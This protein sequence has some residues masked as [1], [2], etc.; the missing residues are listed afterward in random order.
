MNDYTNG[1]I[2]TAKK[3]GI[4]EKEATNLLKAAAQADPAIAEQMQAGSG[5]PGAEQM[6]QGQ[7]PLPGGE[8]DSG[9]PP[10]LEQLINSLPPEVLEQLLAE[11]EQELQGGGDPAAQGAPP[12]GM[13]P[14][15]MQG[16]M[17][18]EG[19]PKQG[20]ARDTILAKTAEYQE[21]FVEAANYYGVDRNTTVNLYKQAMVEMENNPV[22]A[23]LFV[24]SKE[25]RAAHFEGFVYQA[26]NRGF[27]QADAI[28]TYENTFLK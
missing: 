23:S 13:P 16:G 25:K 3:N 17:P 8:G 24:D 7:P 27:S 2:E 21:G 20:S 22:D 26:L 12:Q 11:V 9:I 19:M 15:A 28:S 5:A 10:E 14:E 4:S 6:A 1:F 18:P